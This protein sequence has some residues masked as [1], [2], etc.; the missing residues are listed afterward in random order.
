M[1]LGASWGPFW[2]RFGS[3]FSVVFRSFFGNVLGPT[4][5]RLWLDLDAMGAILPPFWE[6][7]REP[8]G[9]VRFEPTLK[10]EP[11]FHCPRESEK[12]AFF[13]LLSERPPEHPLEP[14]WGG[15]GGI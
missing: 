4:L 6:P 5:A 14:L 7:F 1:I 2:V 3:D 12:R 8:L 9:E 13:D 10:R 15:L 11:R